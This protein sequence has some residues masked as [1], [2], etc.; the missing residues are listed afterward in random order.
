MAA[1]R[2]RSSG[3]TEKPK[4]EAETEEKEIEEFLDAAATEMFET[5]SQEEEEASPVIEELT[6]SA[7][8]QDLPVP[9]PAPEP[10]A[11]TKPALAPRPK[12]PRRPQR[13]VPRFSRVR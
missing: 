8:R 12:L 11:A 6:T 7:V 10:P 1:S 13:N 4:S 2:R 5:I 9:A 3:F